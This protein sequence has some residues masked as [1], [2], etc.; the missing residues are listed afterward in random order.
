M[1]FP[2]VFTQ[3]VIVTLEMVDFEKASDPKQMSE[4]KL[5]EYASSQ[6]E[7]GSELF[8]KG[9]IHLALRR[10]GKVLEVFKP[11]PGI[12]GTSGKIQASGVDVSDKSQ[13]H[14]SELS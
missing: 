9:R 10:Y 12:L 8:R 6:K 1:A 7:L 11:K 4:V 5:M 14:I 2:K 13:E 3:K